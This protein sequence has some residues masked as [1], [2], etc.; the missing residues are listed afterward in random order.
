MTLVPPQ[1]LSGESRGAPC[2]SG[3]CSC[4]DGGS[5]R[6]VVVQLRPL[7]ETQDEQERS[8]R[9]RGLVAGRALVGRAECV[10]SSGPG[11]WGHWEARGH[12]AALS[13]ASGPLCSDW[14]RGWGQRGLVMLPSK[15]AIPKPWSD[16]GQM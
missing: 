10:G 4:G 16:L 14:R 11:R 1:A 3:S 12:V 9:S 2:P 15:R 7:E 6:G 13:R 5:Q 8:G